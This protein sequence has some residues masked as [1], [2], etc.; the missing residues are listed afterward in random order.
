MMIS[1]TS[2]LAFLHYFQHKFAAKKKHLLC[3]IQSSSA[4]WIK[5]FLALP[6][7]GR[8]KSLPPPLGQL[9]GF[10]LKI[11]TVIL[12]YFQLEACKLKPLSDNIII[13]LIGHAELL[14]SHVMK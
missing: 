7:Q 14:F 12:F 9:L 3:A 11:G 10:T 2:A 1:L 4:N 13:N 8:M 6:L 5:L